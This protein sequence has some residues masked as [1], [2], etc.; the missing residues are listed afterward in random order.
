MM[1]NLTMCMVFAQLPGLHKCV[2]YV[3]AGIYRCVSGLE[4]EQ[5]GEGKETVPGLFLYEEQDPPLEAG[6]VG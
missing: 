6:C 1:N 2:S 4:I 5:G 3:I